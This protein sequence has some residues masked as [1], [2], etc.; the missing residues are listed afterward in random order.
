MWNE[1][2]FGVLFIIILKIEINLLKKN[3]KILK[4]DYI[5]IYSK[6]L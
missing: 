4:I 6:K 3:P 1:I 5:Y 2:V